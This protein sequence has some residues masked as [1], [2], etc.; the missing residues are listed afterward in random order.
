MEFTAG[1]IAQLLKGTVEGNPDIK[2]NTIAKIEAGHEGAL[3]FLANPKYEHFI[4]TTGSSA[5]LVRN[6]FKPLK[7]ISATLIRVADPYQSIAVLLNIYEQ[8]KPKKKGIHPTA[9]IEKSAK[10][11]NDVFIGAYVYVG[12]NA[13]I[14]DNCSLYPYVFMGDDTKLGENSALHPSVIIYNGCV[15]GRDCI[16]HAGT[17]IGAD[18]FGFAP[19]ADNN[20]MKIPQI[21][22]VVIEDN[23]EIGANTCIDRST[24]GSTIIHKGVKLDNLVQIGH[25]VEIGE[26]TVSA[27]LTGVAG[28]SKVGKNCMIGG[29]VGIVGHISIADGTKV[30]AQA[31]IIGSVKEPDSTLVGMP[32]IDNR[33]YMRSYAVFMRLPDI[34]K[35]I[36][37]LIKTVES[38]KNK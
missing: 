17:V 37:E 22:N 31:G 7:S 9:I 10:I 1:M 18:G 33:K 25:N 12:E 24:M 14:S 8:S 34:D 36:D 30:G 16:I 19:S 38:L 6:D 15:I 11:G 21:G 29:Q 4:Y 23:V 27:A 32:A 20:Y 3:S 35:K 28:S 5:V 26:N 13:V 2:L